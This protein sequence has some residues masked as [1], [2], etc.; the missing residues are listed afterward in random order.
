MCQYQVGLAD[1]MGQLQQ[2]SDLPA[3]CRFPGCRKLRWITCHPQ[4]VELAQ[5][6]DVRLD[7][8]KDLVFAHV[9]QEWPHRVWI[10]GLHLSMLR[11]VTDH[12][13]SSGPACNAFSNLL[14]LPSI[15]VCVQLLSSLLGLVS[16][17]LL[18]QKMTCLTPWRACPPWGWVG[19]ASPGWIGS[20]P[21]YWTL[22]QSP[23]ACRRHGLHQRGC[24]RLESSPDPRH[25]QRPSGCHSGPLHRPSDLC[26]LIFMGGGHPPPHGRVQIHCWFPGCC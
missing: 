6:I 11:E 8:V 7:A 3:G 22:C 15:E 13:V 1:G 17:L 5:I 23:R 14:V 20:S 9:V 4:D 2:I 12:G 16:W 19:A 21:P 24:F 18:P 10:I 25:H 26:I